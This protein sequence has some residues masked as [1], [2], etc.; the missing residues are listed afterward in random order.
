MYAAATTT[1]PCRDS[2]TASTENVDT[3]VNPPKAPMP[4]N[5][6]TRRPGLPCSTNAMSTP[7]PKDPSTLVSRVATGKPPAERGSSSASP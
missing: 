2:S 4:R 1:S 6:R 5:G 3:V 7:S